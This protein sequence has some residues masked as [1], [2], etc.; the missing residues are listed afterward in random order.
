MEMW[1]RLE[2]LKKFWDFVVL[3]M[4]IRNRGKVMD[5]VPSGDR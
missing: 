1:Q 5:V 3:G 4:V 2:S